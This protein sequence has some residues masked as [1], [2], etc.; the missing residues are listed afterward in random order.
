MEQIPLVLDSPSMG[1]RSAIVVKEDKMDR[2]LGLADIY[3]QMGF[4]PLHLPFLILGTLA[5][6]YLLQANFKLNKVVDFVTEFQIR[7]VQSLLGKE[8][9][10][11]DLDSQRLFKTV[12]NY[13]T[14]FDKDQAYFQSLVSKGVVRG[15]ETV[16][17][18]RSVEGTIDLVPESRFEPDC[19]VLAA[20]FFVRSALP[21]V[22]A[23]SVATA[24]ALTVASKAMG[25]RQAYDVVSFAEMVTNFKTRFG[26]R[27][28]ADGIP[29]PTRVMDV[30]IVKTGAT[31]TNLV[32]TDVF[33]QTPTNVDPRDRL[34]RCTFKY[35]TLLSMAFLET[36]SPKYW[37]Q[38]SIYGYFVH[39]VIGEGGNGYVLAASRDPKSE[40]R[41][42]LKVFKLFSS[43]GTTTLTRKNIGEFM[44]EASVL[45]S[46]NHRNLVKVYAVYVDSV[47][48]NEI[49]SGKTETFL[50]NPP[51]LVFEFMAGGN[52]GQAVGK[53][54][55]LST[56]A[57]LYVLWYVGSALNYLHY[58]NLVHLDVKPNNIFVSTPYSNKE[59]LEKLLANG[60][61]KLGDLGSA[62]REGGRFFAVTLE[63]SPPE[64]VEGIIT[65][66]PASKSMDVFGLGATAYALLIG[67]NFNPQ[68]VVRLYSDA[69]NDYVAGGVEWTNYIKKAKEE[70]KA[71]WETLQDPLGGLIKKMTNPDPKQRPTIKEV[72]GEVETL[73]NKGA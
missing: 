53:F 12:S 69:L 71:F 49:I 41:Y 5:S 56:N 11:Y 19:D 1:M 34:S 7:P 42:A 68:G 66:T 38:K 35:P 70:Y 23:F 32:V 37:I 29:D 24:V 46:L 33:G 31:E 58:L 55:P 54:G 60:D 40:P 72:L 59:G 21:T 17:R 22:N 64:Q 26:V 2:V 50:H 15:D 57:V 28:K 9:A 65:K 20:Y 27:L 43:A 62:V 45:T 30:N 13:S 36:F 44:R 61:V 18:I 47:A 4:S 39:S 73:L 48:I 25:T 51:L 8:V 63:Y 67:K 3:Y 52:L 10:V 14:N 16:V 6:P